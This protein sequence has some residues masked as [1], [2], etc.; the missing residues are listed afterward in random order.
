MD[1]PL[2]ILRDIDQPPGGWKYLVPETGLQLSSASFQGLATNVRAHLTA[3]KIPIPESFLKWL[4]NEVCS[5]NEGMHNI[6][7]KT[8]KKQPAGMLANLS[9]SSLGRFSRTMMGVVRSRRFVTQDEANRRAEIC[10][11]CPLN[12]TVGGCQGCFSFIH[13]VRKLLT[14]ITTEAKPD[15]CGACGCD[16]QLKVWIPND[17]LNDAETE[18]PE[19]AP[20]CW[21]RDEPI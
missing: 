2:T 20:N 14:N 12:V 3:N 1:F 4:G 9:P 21:R 5:Q 7:G 18:L 13:E 17:I 15:F 11:G 6:C 8:P 10:M 16:L 19:Y